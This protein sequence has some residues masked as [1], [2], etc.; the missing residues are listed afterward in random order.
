MKH[1]SGTIVVVMLAFC[2]MSG[3]HA[4]A[5]YYPNKTR[6]HLTRSILALDNIV[7]QTGQG[8]DEDAEGI[9]NRARMLHP[10]LGRFAQRDPLEYP[11]GM[12]RYQYE[13]S[14]AITRKDASGLRPLEGCH[15]EVDTF[16]VPANRSGSKM[17]EIRGDNME[18]KYEIYETFYM[19]ATFKDDGNNVNSQ[20]CEYRQYVYGV[21]KING[22]HL[23]YRL[24]G[25]L[26][27]Y[28]PPAPGELPLED[29]RRNAFPD[30]LPGGK[31]FFY[32][33]RDF[34]ET[35]PDVY[36]NPD[37]QT[38]KKYAG[39]D[40]PAMTVGHKERGEMYLTFIGKIIDVCPGNNGKTKK[41]STWQVNI[42]MI[43]Y[44]DLGSTTRPA[45]APT[46]RPS[47]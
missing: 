29:G 16:D 41:E 23:D 46:S 20:C 2:F 10:G 11:D 13:V 33:H 31:H 18:V 7:A 24:P 22:V 5:H 35:P 3:S 14:N 27:N 32:G 21:Y 39:K 42:N 36:S 40:E 4:D 6:G 34:P 28:D 12:N 43:G 15:C 1:I 19:N 30:A 47:R 45:T 44:T 17:R 37:R 9:E 38:G 26:L 8:L 25:G